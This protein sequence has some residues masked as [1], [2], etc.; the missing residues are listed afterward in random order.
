MTLDTHQFP[1]DELRRSSVLTS[2]Q[3]GDNNNNYYN[4]EEPKKFHFRFYSQFLHSFHHHIKM[5]LSHGSIS[6]QLQSVTVQ[7]SCQSVLMAPSQGFGYTITAFKHCVK[8]F[9]FSVQTGHIQNLAG[10]KSQ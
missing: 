5:L 4:N 10:E 8:P 1:R 6:A 9:S 3:D 7:T 2:S